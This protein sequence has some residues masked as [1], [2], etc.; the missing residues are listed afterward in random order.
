MLVAALEVQH[1]RALFLERRVGGLQFRVGLA[2]GKPAC[3]GVE[4]HVENVGLFAE[5]LAAAVR[6]GCA[7]GQQRFAAVV[8]QASTP[9]RSNSSTI[10]RF[11]AASMIG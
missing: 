10:L 3:A 11:S 1:L 8:C 5:L 9:S 4:P 2:D 6:A 7:G